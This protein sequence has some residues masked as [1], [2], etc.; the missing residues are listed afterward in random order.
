MLNTLTH[1][2]TSD[3]HNPKIKKIFQTKGTWL[4]TSYNGIS[5]VVP[6]SLHHGMLG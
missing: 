2:I 5:L 6:V 1:L 3:P 4:R